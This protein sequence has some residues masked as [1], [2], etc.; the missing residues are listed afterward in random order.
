M[1]D[2]QKMT[3][4]VTEPENLRRF[5]TLMLEMLVM[6]DAEREEFFAAIH[7]DLD[8]RILNLAGAAALFGVGETTVKRWL[9]EGAT[10]PHQVIGT[11]RYFS[12]QAILAWLAQ[13]PEAE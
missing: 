13:R 12:K 6:T 5:M 7:S 8:D 1:A 4:T 10:I 2:E 11:K 3:R 9:R